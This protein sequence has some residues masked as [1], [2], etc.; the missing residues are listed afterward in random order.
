MTVCLLYTVFYLLCLYT[1]LSHSVR[2]FVGG[3][4]YGNVDYVCNTMPTKFV[5]LLLSNGD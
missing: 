2:P 4:E 1:F 5:R 3:E